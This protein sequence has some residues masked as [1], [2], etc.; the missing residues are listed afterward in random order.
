MN[1]FCSPLSIEAL[2]VFRSH[3][4]CLFLKSMV[5]HHI[6]TNNPSHLL[7]LN[8]KPLFRYI[9]I[10]P[11]VKIVQFF[12]IW[13]HLICNNL[14]VYTNL[15]KS[16]SNLK[17]NLLHVNVTFFVALYSSLRLHMDK[18]WNLKWF[19]NLNVLYYDLCDL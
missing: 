10:Q 9:V 2:N 14:S 8:L 5:S 12:I 15:T 19:I 6:T 1:L 18:F 3:F 11:P 4:F 7:N 13:Q 16:T 17:A